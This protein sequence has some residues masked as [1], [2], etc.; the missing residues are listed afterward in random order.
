MQTSRMSDEAWQCR[1]MVEHSPEIHKILF[2]SPVPQEAGRR[3]RRRKRRRREKG[4][5][6]R[7][8]LHLNGLPTITHPGLS[9]EKES[10]K[11]LNKCPWVQ[12]FSEYHQKGSGLLVRHHSLVNAHCRMGLLVLRPL[13]LSFPA[14]AISTPV[15][16]PSASL[17]RGSGS[18]PPALKNPCLP[19]QVVGM[20]AVGCGFDCLASQ[21]LSR[22]SYGPL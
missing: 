5:G 6:E 21:T 7:E 1:P 17:L 18:P 9:T 3:R 12:I 16:F 22:A 14:R 11:K 2:Q 20:P 10:W 19:R 4:D 8:S 15:R 13:D